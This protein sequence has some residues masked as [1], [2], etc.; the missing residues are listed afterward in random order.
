[1]LG[2]G[3]LDQDASAGKLMKGS[4]LMDAMVSS[5]MSRYAA[6]QTPLPYFHS[7]TASILGR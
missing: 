3:L 7:R 6:D 5:V 1:M 4:L 2:A